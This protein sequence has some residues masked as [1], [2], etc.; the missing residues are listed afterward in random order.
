MTTLLHKEFREGWRTWRFLIL[1][2]VLAVSGLISPLLAYFTPQ[3]LKMANLPAN[4]AGIIPEPSTADAV[5]QY[6]KNG[7]MFG[8]ILL[9]VF[10]MGAIAAEKE[11]GLA[12]MLFVRPVR[13]TS[14]VLAKW[15][16]WAL[17]LLVSVIVSGILAYAYTLV[18]FGS[19]PFGPFLLLNALLYLAFLPYLTLALMAS[20]LV[21][22]QGAAAGLAFGSWILLMI[23][24]SLPR[25]GEYMPGQLVN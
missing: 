13:R 2:I 1:L 21:K 9:I 16:M 19:L 14:A 17:V 11:R 15:L 25:I 7:T 10:G 5:A 12:A 3:I 18:L 24:N 22:S 4:L 8:Q 20:A 23:V 6:V